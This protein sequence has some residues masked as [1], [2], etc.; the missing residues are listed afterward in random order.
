[1]KGYKATDKN[2]KC[3]GFQYELGKWYE[4]EGEL[5]ECESGFHFCEQPSG[6]WAYYSEPGARIFESEAEEVL[7]APF[8][9]GADFKR[10][11]RRIRFVREINIGGCGNTG[12]RNTGDWNTGCGNTGDW[13]TG[14]RNTGDWNTGDWNTGD[15]NTGY[16]NTGCG[17]TG[18]RN[19][20]Y[21]NTGDGNTGY[22]NTGDG[23]TG[24]RNT[25]DWNTGDRNTGCGNTGDWNTGDRN[26]GDRNTGYRNTG[27][28]NTGDRN[29]G[30]GNTGHWNATDYSTGFFCVNEP[31][32]KSFDMQTKMTHEEFL[33]A[34]PE[35]YDLGVALTQD[36]PIE[37]EL[38]KNIPGITKTKLKSLHDKHIAGRKRQGAAR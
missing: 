8:E 38:Y 15:R 3:K 34:Y 24:D 25:G 10:V 31:K 37:F 17:N 9:P 36:G 6:P 1:M 32:V 2:M 20:G 7:S 12:D 29:T 19:T 33:K 27:D 13:N 4:H 18:D 35:V 30:C 22:R 11:A 21:R 5:I 14:D 26:T 23:N 16:S 28:G